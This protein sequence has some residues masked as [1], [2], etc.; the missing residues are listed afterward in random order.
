MYHQH[1]KKA[2]RIQEQG[3]ITINRKKKMMKLQGEIEFFETK[4]N[5]KDARDKFN[6]YI[7]K[8]RQ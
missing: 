8:R 4:G 3:S 5:D 6:R 7:R 1:K 2:K